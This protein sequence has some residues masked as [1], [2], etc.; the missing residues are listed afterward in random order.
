M[1]VYLNLSNDAGG[2]HA[3]GHVDSIAPNIILRL[4]CPDHPSDD[5]SEVDPDTD[6]EIIE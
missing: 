3:A 5:R 4:L 6:F 2:V 1:T